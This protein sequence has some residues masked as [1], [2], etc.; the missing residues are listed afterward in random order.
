MTQGGPLDSTLSVVVPHLQP[1]RLR[2]LRLRGGDEL[3]ALRRDRA[4]VGAAVPAAGRATDATERARWPRRVGR[5]RAVRPAIRRP[6]LAATRSRAGSSRSV[7][8]CTWLRRLGSARLVVTP[9]VWMAARRRSSPRARS[10]RCRRPGGRRRRRW[11]TT[12]TLFARLDFP[13]LLPQLGRSSRS[14]VTLGTCCSARCSATRW[15]SCDFPGS[16]ALFL[17][18]ARHADGARHGHV[19][20]AV[21]A[22]QQ[23]GP[24]QHVRRP[25]PA[26]PR[27]AVRRVPDAAVHAVA[28]RTSCIEAARVDGAGELRIFCADRAAAVPAGAR[29]ARHPHVPRVVEQLPVA[30]RRGHHRGQV[31]AAGRAGAVQRRAEP[32]RV[33]PAAGR[34]G[35]GRAAGP[36]RRSSSLQRHFV[37]GIATTGLKYHDED[38]ET[39][40]TPSPLRVAC[41]P[42]SRARAAVAAPPRPPADRRHAPTASTCARGT[43]ARH[44]AVDGRDDRPATGLPADNI[45]GDLD[46][47]TRSA[48][49]SPTNI[50]A[51]PVVGGR[52]RATSGII[53]KREARRAGSAD[54]GHAGRRSSGTSRPG[55]FYNWYDPATGAVLTRLARG[56]QHRLPVPVQCGQRLA[57]RRAA[58]SSRARCRSCA[59][60]PTRCS[61]PMNF[62]FYYNPDRPTAPAG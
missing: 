22:G 30:A 29:H 54:P 60:R 55:M 27:R 48:Y 1:V 19:R 57:R 37:R 31:H 61:T 26:V 43:P 62:G 15:P 3:R 8:R 59:A 17:A 16:R 25:D 38:Y 32:D 12:A 28:S 20:A 10:A 7:R 51:L 5:C 4:A 46:P 58:W 24:G 47:R 40:T 50:G 14:L 56:R 44:L 21:R 11:T 49:T 35:R 33:R 42:P 36:D 18:R 13:Q 23:P 45:A 34:R 6:A 2:Q 9:F 41:S 52:R 39:A 53:G